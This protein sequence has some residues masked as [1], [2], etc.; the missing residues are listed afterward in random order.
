MP[1]AL[2]ARF[3]RH[4]TLSR[5][6]GERTGPRGNPTPPLAQGGALPRRLGDTHVREGGTAMATVKEQPRQK[7]QPQTAGGE[8]AKA[9]AG[10]P[11]QA[12]S[13][14]SMA[15]YRREP[16]SLFREEMN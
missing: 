2:P 16:F 3:L 9:T 14:G 15:P 8:Q 1:S 6:G 11:A 4:R 7:E 12:P 10:P 13:G 5:A